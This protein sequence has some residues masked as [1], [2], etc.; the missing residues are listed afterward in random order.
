MKMYSQVLV[1]SPQNLHE[2][3]IELI[4]YTK[5]RHLHIVQNRYSPKDTTIRLV[6]I[7]IGGILF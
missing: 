3:I 5:L 2:D 7:I 6:I 4:G 1:I